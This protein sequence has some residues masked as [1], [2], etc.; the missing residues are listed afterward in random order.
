M[1]AVGW[2]QRLELVDDPAD[3]VAAVR[4]EPSHAMGTRP[5]RAVAR[6]GRRFRKQRF[7][8]KVGDGM[9][10]G[11]I[12]EHRALLVLIRRALSLTLGPCLAPN[13]D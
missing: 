4:H 10:K 2:R 1:G 11:G 3:G 12:G 8:P 6:G 5:A 7:T 9:D 13:H